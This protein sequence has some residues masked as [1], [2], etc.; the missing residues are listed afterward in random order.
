MFEAVGVGDNGRISLKGVNVGGMD[1]AVEAEL[2]GSG[3]QTK[4]KVATLWH[5]DVTVINEIG[6]RAGK[7][8]NIEPV[9]SEVAIDG[10]LLKAPLKNNSVSVFVIE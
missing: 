10:D 5:D 1:A 2:Y 8:H 9:E 7:V 4:A 3:K 6:V